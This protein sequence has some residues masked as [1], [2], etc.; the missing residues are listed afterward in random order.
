MRDREFFSNRY[1]ALELSL[2]AS[3]RTV[4]RPEG[5]L[6]LVDTAPAVYKGLQSGF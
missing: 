4:S 1:R 5:L 3:R 2:A 6:G